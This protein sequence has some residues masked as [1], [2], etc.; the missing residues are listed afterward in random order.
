MYLNFKN[1]EVVINFRNRYTNL[2][3][4]KI[5]LGGFSRKLMATSKESMSKIQIDDLTWLTAVSF[6]EM[7]SPRSSAEMLIFT[8]VPE[9]KL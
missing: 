6:F 9:S 7:K 2:T 5:E 4:P 1:G 8:S 3:L